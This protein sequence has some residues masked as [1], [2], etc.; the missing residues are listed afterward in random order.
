MAEIQTCPLCHSKASMRHSHDQ[1]GCYWAHIEC[2]KCGLRTR[3]NW[4][5]TRSEADPI[6]YEEVR[7]AWNTRAARADSTEAQA[8]V[9]DRADRTLRQVLKDAVT[10]GWIG[11]DEKAE[12][13]ALR[14][15]QAR[16][17]TEAVASDELPL[18]P[19]AAYS[20]DLHDGHPTV[21]YSAQQMYDFAR[22]SQRLKVPQR[23][24][25][26]DALADKCEIWLTLGGAS[27]VVDAYEAGYRDC[28]LHHG[29]L[30]ASG[31]K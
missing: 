4:C 26:P 3:G 25:T 5:S 23:R 28:E 17:L 2:D 30:P 9:S 12:I 6:F 31:E 19:A 22:A 10:L 20:L 13:L 27:N 18:L 11:E 15:P 1:D 21:A 7:D 29:I 14:A 24:L 8:E 16:Q